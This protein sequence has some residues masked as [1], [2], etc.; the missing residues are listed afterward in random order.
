MAIA[1]SV[2]ASEDTVFVQGRG[3]TRKSE[4]K[5]FCLCYPHYTSRERLVKCWVLSSLFPLMMMFLWCWPGGIP[6]IIVAIDRVVDGRTTGEGRDAFRPGPASGLVIV[7][8]LREVEASPR[9][10][11][12]VLKP[13]LTRNPSIVESENLVATLVFNNT[14]NHRLPGYATNT[15]TL[16]IIDT[17]G[18]HTFAKGIWSM[19]TGVYNGGNVKEVFGSSDNAFESS[20]WDSPCRNKTSCTIRDPL[21]IHLLKDTQYMRQMCEQESIV[22]THLG[23]CAWLYFSND[24]V[25]TYNRGREKEEMRVQGTREKMRRRECKDERGTMGKERIHG[26]KG[27][28]REG[29]KDEQASFI[30][31]PGILK[32]DG[33]NGVADNGGDWPTED[34]SERKLERRTDRRFFPIVTRSKNC[35]GV[36]GVADNGGDWPTEDES[37]RKL[38]SGPR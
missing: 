14:P 13:A 24:Y 29:G 15:G 4:R 6:V 22:S 18:V 25:G 12:K 38:A 7:K 19:K 31:W 36:N 27:R 11:E 37:E 32:P 35:S 2:E 30:D 28:G 33:V 1:V 8:G 5:A 20:R 3:K 21:L 23:R 34:E 17:P 10:C 9:T 26:V 16:C